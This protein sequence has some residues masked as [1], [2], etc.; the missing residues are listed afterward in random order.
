M[1]PKFNEAWTDPKAAEPRNMKMG[2]SR[3]MVATPDYGPQTFEEAIHRE[4][5]ITL[6][7]TGPKAAKNQYVDEYRTPLGIRSAALVSRLVK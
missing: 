6:E 2:D 1:T 3:W 4:I 7:W 5:I